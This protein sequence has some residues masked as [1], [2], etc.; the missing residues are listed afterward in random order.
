MN[1]YEKLI[2]LHVVEKELHNPNLRGNRLL[3][4]ELG[5]LGIG[6]LVIPGGEGAY[7]RTGQGILLARP[8]YG[9]GTITELGK[10]Q[11]YGIGSGGIEV[12]RTRV[13]VP[14]ELEDQINVLNGPKLWSLDNKCG[15]YSLIEDYMP[16]TKK[17]NF[18]ENLESLEIDDLIGD[19]LVVKANFSMGS[20]HID[21]VDR[22]NVIE[23]IKKMRNGFIRE[24]IESGALRK[25]KTI[26]VQEY[27]P[28]VKWTELAGVDD[29]NKMT[30]QNAK[31]TE[32]RVYCSVDTDHKIP[33]S[34]RYYAT[35][36]VFDENRRD[37]WASIDQSS[38]PAEVWKFADIISDRFFKK[39]AVNGGYFAIDFIKSGLNNQNG[40]RILVREANFSKPVMVSER[41]NANDA[42][43]QNKLLANL[44]SAMIKSN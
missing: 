18:D 13:V 16:K 14:S 21:I 27:V 12:V 38:V 22:A 26:L 8:T 41:Y 5:K 2:A 3:R 11:E 10:I 29:D 19:K 39:A 37:D 36:R 28:G 25:N 7:D 9:S 1:D 6:T 32:L 35:A 4:N 15:Q 42:A 33:M 20:K 31:D 17:I 23:S 40:Q 43:I 34:G 44:I 30:L 24:E